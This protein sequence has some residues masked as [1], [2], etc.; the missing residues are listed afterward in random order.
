MNWSIVLNVVLVI[1]IILAVVLGVLYYFGRKL[2]KRQVEQQALLE[3]AAQT[4]SM[5]VIDKKKMK[6]KDANLPK[7]VYEQT[8]KYLRWAKVPLVKAKVGPKVATLIADEKVF[9]A[10]PLKTEVKVVISGIYITELKSV[11]G[12]AVPAP[13]KKKGFFDRFKKEHFKEQKN[14]CVFCRLFCIL[15]FCIFMEMLGT[16]LG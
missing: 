2:E 3:A 14:S 15:L 16:P 11:R 7:I 9:A 6:I 4:V 13:V 8:P 1:F 10:L 5:L 12:G